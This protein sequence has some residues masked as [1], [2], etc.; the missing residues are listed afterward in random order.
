MARQPPSSL[1]GADD[2][3]GD[4]AQALIRELLA[5]NQALEQEL[6]QSKHQDSPSGH[7]R[8]DQGVQGDT[9][10]EPAMADPEPEKSATIDVADHDEPPAKPT[11]R[12]MVDDETKARTCVDCDKTFPTLKALHRCST[13]YQRLYKRCAEDVVYC[14][15]R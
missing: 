2:L 11:T 9:T 10:P 8:A 4:A 14:L 15:Q 3:S 12:E 13:C 6:Q 1:P 7:L 5:R